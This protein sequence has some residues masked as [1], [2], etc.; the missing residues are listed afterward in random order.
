[1]AESIGA[2]GFACSPM[3]MWVFSTS[4]KDMNLDFIGY[5]RLTSGLNVSMTGCLTGCPNQLGPAARPR[6]PAGEK[7]VEDGWMVGWMDDDIV[8]HI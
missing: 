8:S 5:C 2:R 1:M 3:F 7:L 6:D 4:S